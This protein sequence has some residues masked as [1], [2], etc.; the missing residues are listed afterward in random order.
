[1]R[2]L[3]T[4]IAINGLMALVS[5]L[6]TQGAKGCGNLMVFFLWLFVVMTGVVAFAPDRSAFGNWW[7]SSSGHAITSM[8]R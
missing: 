2:K 1:M 7:T 5:V 8:S 4:W 3:I 6:A